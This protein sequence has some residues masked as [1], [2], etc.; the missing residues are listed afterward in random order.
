MAGEK[1]RPKVIDQQRRKCWKIELS[2][3]GVRASDFQRLSVRKRPGW[4]HADD[5]TGVMK[6][7]GDPF[8]LG[9]KASGVAG[10]DSF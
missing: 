2:E 8:V 7:R 1:P 4:H 6:N 5:D 9:S 3:F 10:P